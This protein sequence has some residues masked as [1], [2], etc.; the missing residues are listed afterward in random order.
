[1][2]RICLN[3]LEI[4]SRI[5][6]QAYDSTLVEVTGLNPLEIGSRILTHAAMD[7]AWGLFVLIP[8]KS[9]LGFLHTR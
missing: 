7:T 8:S 6:T 3:P 1:M 5:L 4:G 2:K 9:G